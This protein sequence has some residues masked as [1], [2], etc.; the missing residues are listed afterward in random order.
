M[1]C[2]LIALT[3]NLQKNLA[4]IGFRRMRMPPIGNLELKEKG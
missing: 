1:I 4:L 3:K 2:W